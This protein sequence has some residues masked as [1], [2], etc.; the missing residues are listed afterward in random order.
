MFTTDPL[1]PADAVSAVK[2]LS[3]ASAA[4]Q[5][6]YHITQAN[7]ATALP[8]IHHDPDTMAEINTALSVGKEVITHTDSISVPGWTGAGYIIFDP[9]T[10]DGAYK[11]A[12]G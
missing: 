8:N 6:I 1:N 4:G 10:G 3:K 2:A 5:R 7:Q 9:Q 12:G 11:I